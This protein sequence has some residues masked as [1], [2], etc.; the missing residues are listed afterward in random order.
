MAHPFFGSFPM[1]NPPAPTLISTKAALI[2]ANIDD[3]TPIYNQLPNASMMAC[4]TDARI[5]IDQF[6]DCVK[7]ALEA[8]MLFDATGKAQIAMHHAKLLKCLEN[9]QICMR[10]CHTQFENK[11]RMQVDD[12]AFY[13]NF[14]MMSHFFVQEAEGIL[15]LFK[16]Y[17]AMG[18]TMHAMD[19]MHELIIKSKCA[20]EEETRRMCGQALLSARTMGRMSACEIPEIM[21][22]VT[23]AWIT[24]L[25]AR[26]QG[27]V[28]AT[29]TN[30]F[31]SL[32]NSVNDLRKCESLYDYHY[33]SVKEA[34]HFR[35]IAMACCE[36]DNIAE[37]KRR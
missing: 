25:N 18:D 31:N 34:C 15:G 6:M 21:W 14:K 1:N 13:C 7:Q 2:Q 4:L 8:D 16:L 12:K 9:L 3:R 17:H 22:Q 28:A 10:G 30:A 35:Q 24:Q 37:A 20:S 27:T 36:P 26:G 23:M 33:N 19:D 29:V 5:C 11:M 32:I